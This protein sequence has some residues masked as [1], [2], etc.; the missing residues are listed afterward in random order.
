MPLSPEDLAHLTRC[1]EL[2]ERAVEAGDQPFGS[3]LIDSAGVIRFE[4]H[5]H[6]G[7]GDGPGIRVDG[8]APELADRLRALHHGFH[9]G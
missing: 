2:A 4:D 7:G 1:V 9:Q 6:E 8:P 3:L 5:N